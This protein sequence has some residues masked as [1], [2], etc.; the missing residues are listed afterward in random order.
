MTEKDT[1]IIPP[2]Q[3]R[4]APLFRK[5]RPLEELLRDSAFPYQV[6]RLIGASEVVAF[7]LQQRPEGDIAQMGMKLHSVVEFF[8]EKR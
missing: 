1:E 2:N 5:A 4:R 3:G 7:W 8:Y 6:G